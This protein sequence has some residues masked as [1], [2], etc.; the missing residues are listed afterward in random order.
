MITARAR[1][2][3]AYPDALALY[4]SDGRFTD[5]IEE[6]LH[7]LGFPRLDTLTLPGGPALVELTS[8]SLAANEVA[9]SSLSFLVTAHHLKHVVLVAHASCGYYKHRFAYESPEAMLRRQYAD[10]RGAARWVRGQ[11]AGVAVSAF[12]A[13]TEGAVVTFED[14]GEPG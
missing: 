10:L 7:G 12:Y 11:H 1:F 13:R 6:L 14:V 8:S 4:C 3:A 9:R 5:A 2:D